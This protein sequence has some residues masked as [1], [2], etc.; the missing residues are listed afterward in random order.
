MGVI[1]IDVTNAS[2]ITRDETS[3][4][5]TRGTL[6][7]AQISKTN[8]GPSVPKFSYAQLAIYH[9]GTA[10]EQRIVMLAEGNVL[11]TYALKWDGQIPIDSNMFLLLSVQGYTNDVTRAVC[12]TVDP[13]T[14]RTG[15]VRD[16]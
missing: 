15:F 1:S 7:S 14:G 6:T 12:T 3:H 13:V 10:P 9:L 11:D 5:L 16:P 4:G 2:D 8:N